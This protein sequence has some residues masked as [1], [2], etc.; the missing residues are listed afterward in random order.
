MQ[1]EPS[2]TR[3]SLPVVPRNSEI[4]SKLKVFMDAKLV[5]LDV[6][7]CCQKLTSVPPLPPSMVG[8]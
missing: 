8:C 5:F 4:D 2:S 6:P 7:K 1:E 3:R